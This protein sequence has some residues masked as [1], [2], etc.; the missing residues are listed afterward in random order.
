MLTQPTIEKLCAMRLRGMAEAFQDQQQDPNAHALSFEERLGL[1]IDRQWNW[2]QNRALERR[3][4]TG[5]LQGPACV[6]DID[7]QHPRGL[8]RKL[9]R[10]LTAE[11]AWVREHQ[12]L[13]LIG[14]T[15]LGKTW[16]ARAL[17]QKACRDGYT[18]LFMKANEM[19]RELAMSR[20]DGSHG[21]ALQRFGRVDLLVVDDWAMT[22]L[23]DPERRDFLEICD[24]RYQTRSTLLTS[25]LKVADWHAQIGDPTI[26]D[27][28][29]DRLV[30]NA[31]RL[32]LEG[33]SVRK[34]RQGRR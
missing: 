29:L 14:A 28:I 16:L 27:S 30:H 31:H 25:Q 19:F 2:R 23:S 8:D 21:R 18:A 7:Y 34:L 10:S 26:A 11:S 20:A 22:P 15:G 5:R 32:E 9:I 6:E 4:R 1:L 17:A 13:F 3:L 24:A 33:E 12:N